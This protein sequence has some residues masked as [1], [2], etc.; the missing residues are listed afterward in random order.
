MSLFSNPAFEKSISFNLASM[1]SIDGGAKRG[2]T[3]TALSGF[4]SHPTG[5]LPSNAA[6]RGVVPSHERIVDALA[7]FREAFDEEP[8]QL[9]FETG[10]IR[11]FME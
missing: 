4:T 5:I 11:N 7:R 2:R 6:S 8:R 1:A 10:P 3:R 9:G